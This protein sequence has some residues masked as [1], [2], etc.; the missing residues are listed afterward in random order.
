[1][2]KLLSSNNFSEAG[3]LKSQL[4]AEGIACVIRNENLA[5]G[6]GTVPFMECYPELWVLHDEDF[7]SAQELLAAWQEQADQPMEPWTCPECGEEIEGQ[8]DA[9]WQCGYEK[10]APGQNL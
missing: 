8:F 4:E 2:K 6:S 7:A 1:L 5:I 3:L 9:C 10:E